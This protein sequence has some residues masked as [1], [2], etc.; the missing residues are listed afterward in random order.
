MIKTRQIG[1]HISD[2]YAMKHFRS[3]F[4]CTPWSFLQEAN[5]LDKSGGKRGETTRWWKVPCNCTRCTAV[6]LIRERDIFKT[7]HNQQPDP[8]E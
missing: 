3:G 5:Y 7:I 8:D 1:K 4:W 6:L 2:C